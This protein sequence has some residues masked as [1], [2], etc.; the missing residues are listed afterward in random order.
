MEQFNI[1]IGIF[2]FKRGEKAGLIIDQL[3]KIRPQKLYL[4]GDGPRNDAEKE[5]VEQCRCEVE[6]HITWDCVVI[7]NYAET[8]R[9]VYENIAGGAK[10]VLER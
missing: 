6:K 9:G 1:A 10:W 2:I 7:K 5:E 3:S 4:L 8:N